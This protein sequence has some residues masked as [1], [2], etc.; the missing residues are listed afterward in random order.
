MPLGHAGHAE[1]AG[2]V[3]HAVGTGGG[4]APFNDGRDAVAI[5]KDVA[6]KGIL[7]GGRENGRVLNQGAAHDV[8]SLLHGAAGNR[9][10]SGFAVHR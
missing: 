8:L 6:G 10:C 4:I 1:E 2:A 3:D 9:P 5:D 7:A